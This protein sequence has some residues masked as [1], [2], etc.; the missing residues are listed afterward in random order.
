MFAGI[1]RG[2]CT[3]NTDPG[4]L[5]RIRLLIPQVLGEVESAW[6]LPCVPPGWA[7]GLLNNHTFTDNDTGTGA[8]GSAVETLPHSLKRLVP[9]IGE[10]TWVMFESGD[11]EK[12]VWL[13]VWRTNGG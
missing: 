7:N 12:P 1:Y 10:A 13:G 5:Y 2:V 9:N 3:N 8:G 11:A 6:A 4:G